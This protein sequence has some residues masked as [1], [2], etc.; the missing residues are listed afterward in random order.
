MPKCKMCGRKVNEVRDDLL[1][2]RPN[3][4]AVWLHNKRKCI[5]DYENEGTK[6]APTPAESSEEVSE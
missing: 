1:Y 4:E 3:G 5:D 2:Y 6:P